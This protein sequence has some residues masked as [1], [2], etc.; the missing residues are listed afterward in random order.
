MVCRT[1]RWSRLA[2]V[3]AVLLQLGPG[4][5]GPSAAQEDPASL[6]REYWGERDADAR[7]ALARR[8]ASR[9]DYRPSRLR[10]WLH[11]GVPFEDLAPGA[12]TVTVE[13]GAGETSRVTLVLPEGYRHDRAWPLVYA[14]HPSGEPADRWAEQVRRMLGARAREFVIASPEYRLNYIAAKPPFVAEHAAILDGVARLVHVDAN[15][16]YAFGYSKGGFAA[17]YVA[18][19]FADRFAGAVSLAAGFDVAP[20]E[21]GFWRQLAPN[22]AH[23][24]VFNA[25]GEQD[26]LIVRDLAEKPAGTFAESNRWFAREV[27]GMRLPITNL[28]VPG[29]VH[30][31]LAPPGAP[32]ADIL[33]RS[34]A[35]DPPRVA[36]VFR[37]LNQASSYWLEG[38]SWVGDS[39]GEPWPAR[40]PATPGES[41]ASVLARTL[42]PL[43]GRLTGDRE[44]QAIRVTRRHIGDIVIWLAER[45]IDWD[46][47]VTVECDGKT[48]F[49]GR[50][51]P[52]AELALARARATMD[53]ERLCFAG[54]RVSASG[55]ASIVTA[56]TMPE[57]AW[58][59]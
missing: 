37:H 11:D 36:H 53:F 10:E 50:V 30:N 34:R 21:D 51:A 2:A 43:L 29:G 41:E 45:S 17:W 38:L 47:P 52:D 25:W 48:V 49:S 56:A 26:P 7:S 18:L 20:G 3:L 5:P 57:P 28:E 24:P 23:V 14:L 55:D 15:R 6:V 40:V 22:V 58:R 35:V 54:I 13:A 32:V 31:Q 4:A 1:P 19:Y 33:T 59:R 46:K 12:R 8:I 27:R 42:E 16:V 39:W 9:P 44:G